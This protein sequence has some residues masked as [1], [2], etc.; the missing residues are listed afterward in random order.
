M[1]KVIALLLLLCL[2]LPLVSAIAATEDVVG[3]WY[4]YY[5]KRGTK[6]WSLTDLGL[7]SMKITFEKDGTGLLA[8][9]RDDGTANSGACTWKQKGSKVT[10]ISGSETEYWTL[11]NGKLY[12]ETTVDGEVEKFCMSRK[13]QAYVPITDIILSE[14][15]FTLTRTGKQK[16]PTVTLKAEM[17]PGNATEQEVTW[18]SSKPTVA[19]VD[20]N[21]K[22]T[23]LTAGKTTITCTAADG[24]EVKAKCVIT[25]KDT[26]VKK[27]TLNKTEATL[28]VGRTLKLKVKKFTPESPVNKDV[29]W[30]T[31]KKKVAT[32][33]EKGKVTALKAG[34]AVITCTA[35]D[36]SGKKATC[37]ITVV[38]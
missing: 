24:S 33:D 6:L 10:V 22:V 23:A 3:T 37:T 34:K 31:S 21:G 2:T 18:S 12:R 20:K 8:F 38:K 29:T 14:N 32:V 28:K 36:G 16:K 35:A 11:T 25:V 13:N 9:T 4:F 17:A 7:R 19:K 1:K 30:S 15:K 5:Y 26:K 27:I